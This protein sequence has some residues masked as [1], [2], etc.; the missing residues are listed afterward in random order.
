LLCHSS[1]RG[2]NALASTDIV[3]ENMLE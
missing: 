3:L 2:I 1:R